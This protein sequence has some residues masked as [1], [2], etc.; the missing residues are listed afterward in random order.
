MQTYIVAN[1]VSG[2]TTDIAVRRALQ[3]AYDYHGGQTQILNGKGS[4]ADGVLPSALPCR[5]AADPSHTDIDEARRLLADAGISGLTLTLNYQPTNS[6]QTQEATL[7]QSDLAEI[8]VTVNLV[9][10]AFADYLAS[11]SDPAKIPQLMLLNDQAQTPDPGMVL[12]RTYGSRSVGSTNKSGYRNP[13]VD[14]LLTRAQGTG[15]AATRCDLY[16]QA[17]ELI[18][19]DAVTVNMYSV[20]YPVA[21]RS[22]VTGIKLSHVVNPLAVADLRMA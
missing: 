22:T 16:Q 14:D 8:G 18:A 4:I 15:D 11:L 21:Y 10:I 19:Q 9:P 17:Q 5:P 7:F 12:D 2:P 13:A 20:V 3:L 6:V 1:M